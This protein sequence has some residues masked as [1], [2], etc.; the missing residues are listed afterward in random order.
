M[1][2]NLPQKELDYLQQLVA[3][4]QY[5]TIEEAV[6]GCV[7][8]LRAEQQQMLDRHREAVQIGLD[9]IERGECIEFNSID[10]LR[11]YFEELKRRGPAHVEQT[12][13]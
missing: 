6:I 12:T 4:G 11:T 7:R 13:P 8:L 2:I 1:N 9:Q 3:A 5:A 10:E